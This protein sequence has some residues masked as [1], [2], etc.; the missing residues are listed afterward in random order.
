L[1]LRGLDEAAALDVG[2]ADER[3]AGDDGMR[4]AG[5]FIEH[6]AGVVAGARFAEN[7]TIEGHF[8]VGA[9]D[10]GGTDGTSGNEFDLGEGEAVDE[11]IGGLAR[12]GSFVDGGGKHGKVEAGI[13]EDFGAALGG[14]GED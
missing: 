6:V 7:V 2:E 8:G 13:A 1:D 9:D 4:M 14:G 5:E 12:K 3:D 10:D 11:I